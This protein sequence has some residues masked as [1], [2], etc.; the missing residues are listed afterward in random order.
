M[1]Q[2][3]CTKS[4]DKLL[5]RR[6]MDMPSTDTRAMTTTESTDQKEKKKRLK[7]RFVT[8]KVWRMVV[9][10]SSFFGRRQRQRHTEKYNLNENL[11]SLLALTVR[12]HTC[13]QDVQRF[14]GALDRNHDNIIIYCT[15]NT[16]MS[17]AM[18]TTTLAQN[19]AACR[20]PLPAEW[21]RAS[22][23]IHRN[24]RKYK[25]EDEWKFCK[26]KE[27]LRADDGGVAMAA[28]TKRGRKSGN[29][30]TAKSPTNIIK[31]SAKKKQIIKGMNDILRYYRWQSRE[32]K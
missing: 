27:R 26:H 19:S 23:K 2:P 20:H 13:S 3:L 16:M 29:N 1:S 32:Q 30:T 6:T 12:L 25:C 31:I 5:Q 14:G 21:Q 8:R 22:K 24:R 18:A 15:W 9:C 17:T 28:P 7:N 10:H 4:A 11:S